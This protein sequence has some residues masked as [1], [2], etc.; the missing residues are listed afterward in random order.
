MPASWSAHYSWV[1][2][3][4][5]CRIALGSYVISK[6]RLDHGERR[7]DIAPRV[8][9]SHELRPLEQEVVEHLLSESAACAGVDALE[10]DV[11]NNVQVARKSGECLDFGPRAVV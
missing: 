4:D 7:L 11:G 1:R 6:L 3:I 10:G 5:H 2:S 9:M 8:V